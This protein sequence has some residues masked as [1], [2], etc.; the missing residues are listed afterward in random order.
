MKSQR[1]QDPSPDNSLHENGGGALWAARCTLLARHRGHSQWEL[2]AP[3]HH[4]SARGQQDGPL[5]VCR[6]Q[7]DNFR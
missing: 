7:A 4:P 6:T 1:A 5:G 2:Q 3:Q